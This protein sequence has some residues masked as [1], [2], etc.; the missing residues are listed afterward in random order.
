MEVLWSLEGFCLKDM[1]GL[2]I[3]SDMEQIFLM[4]CLEMN[5][6][7]SNAVDL[8]DVSL[9]HWYILWDFTVKLIF[10]KKKKIKFT[11]GARIIL[12]IEFSFG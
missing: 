1:C 2:P 9:T 5:S 8:A 10:L 11:V 4:P 3:P 6:E 7:K 12:K